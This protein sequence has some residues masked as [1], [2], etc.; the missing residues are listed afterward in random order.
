MTNLFYNLCVCCVQCS[1]LTFY[2]RLGLAEIGKRYMRRMIYALMG[3]CVALSTISP[4]LQLAFTHVRS[5]F[6]QS[7]YYTILWFTNS[8][9]NFLVDLTIWS[10]PL[11]TIFSVM[12]NLSTQKRILLVV[13]FAVGMLSWC[14]S[15][16]R[17]SFWKYAADVDR[18][19]TYNAPLLY[20]LCIAEVSIAI[21]CVSVAALRPLVVK[22]TK[23]FNRLRGKPVSTNKSRFTNYNIRASPSLAKSKGYGSSTSGSK[24]TSNKDGFEEHMIADQELM[25]WEDNVLGTKRSQQQACSC[26]CRD[27][28]IELGGIAAHTSSCASCPDLSQDTKP[29]TPTLA[30]VATDHG[31]IHHPPRCSSGETLSTTSITSACQGAH[32]WPP[33]DAIISSESTVNLTNADSNSRTTVY[34]DP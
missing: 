3:I 22:V 33:C 8:I 28:D 1:I 6:T 12:H 5:L 19:P 7:K 15:I 29:E 13:E 20:I 17:I 16:L 24:K 2:L 32:S 18:D 4:C 9:L 26:T 14:S 34:P 21:G 11:P 25:E 23:G 10:I 31:T 27:G 30:P